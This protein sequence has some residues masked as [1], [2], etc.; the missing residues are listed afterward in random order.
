VWAFHEHGVFDDIKNGL[1]VAQ[2]AKKH[3][4]QE[5]LLTQLLEYLCLSTDIIYREPLQNIDVNNNSKGK[6]E[7]TIIAEN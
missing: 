2:I 3:E 1:S 5:D 4:Y 6:H 7:R